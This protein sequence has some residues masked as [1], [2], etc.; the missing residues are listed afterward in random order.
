LLVLIPAFFEGSGALGSILA[1]RLSSKLHTGL[2]EPRAFPVEALPDVGIV[3]VLAAPVFFF[4]GISAAL[5]SALL[6]FASPGYGQMIS[7]ALLG[8]LFSTTG[9]CLIAYYAAVA[10]VRLG[11]DPDNHGIPLVTSSM[12]LIGAFSLIGAILILG[13]A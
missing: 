8:G 7:V 1:A 10:S 4:A 5:A 3:Y 6:G 13:L 11:L 9:A 2:L 12:D